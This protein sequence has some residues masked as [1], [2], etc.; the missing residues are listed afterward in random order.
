M[1]YRT[2]EG[3]DHRLNH[4]LPVSDKKSNK[5]LLRV[6]IMLFFIIIAVV[7]YLYSPFSKLTEIRIEGNELVEQN[8]ILQATRVQIGDSFLK[9]NTR[10]IKETIEKLTVVK[11]AQVA[12]SFPNTLE[13]IVDEKQVVAYVLD[14]NHAL[15]PLLEDGTI[16]TVLRENVP[17]RPRPLVSSPLTE[18]LQFQMADQLKD[19]PIDVMLALSEIYVNQTVKP[20]QV[21]IYTRNGYELRMMFDEMR[22]KL[23]LYEDIMEGLKYSEPDKGV[24]NMFDAI[25][26]MSY[27]EV[28]KEEIAKEETSKEEIDSEEIQ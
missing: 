5:L 18:T 11:G 3:F 6:I 15:L 10:A 28:I 13:I 24:I 2:S 22:D 9:V 17:N 23:L 26:F 8:L 12:F 4:P 20:Y 21:S 16:L 25:W 27:E 7:I 19:V 14:G 1:S